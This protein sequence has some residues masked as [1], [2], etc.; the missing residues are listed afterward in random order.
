MRAA[1]VYTD[2]ACDKA[3]YGGWG[4]VSGSGKHRGSGAEFPSTNNRMELQAAID[5]LRTVPL[6]LRVL[7]V[8]DSAYVS[9]CFLER[10][11]DKWRANGWVS[12]KKKPV[13]NRELWEELIALVEARDG[14]VSWLHVR[15]HGKRATDDPTHV[16]GNAVADELAVAARVRFRT[17]TGESR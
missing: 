2:G 9:N 13:E 5:A 17:L 3:G 6:G 1:V 14:A 7:L 10:W 16:A 4:W 12:S 15:G 8:T 11:Y